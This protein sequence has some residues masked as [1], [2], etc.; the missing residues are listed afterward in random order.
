[1]QHERGFIESIQLIIRCGQ[2]DREQIP[3]ITFRKIGDNTKLNGSADSKLFYFCAPFAWQRRCFRDI[4]KFIGVD[5]FS[6]HLFSEA[7]W[8]KTGSAFRSLGSVLFLSVTQPN[9]FQFHFSIQSKLSIC[10]DRIFMFSFG[11]A[12]KSHEKKAHYDCKQ[13]QLKRWSEK[14]NLIKSRDLPTQSLKGKINFLFLLIS[15]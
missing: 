12:F 4:M 1:M 3:K 5:R 10:A 8:C 2:V 15:N 14:P 7:F 11:T 6:Q 13:N 9:T